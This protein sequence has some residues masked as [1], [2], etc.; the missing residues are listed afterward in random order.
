MDRGDEFLDPQFYV[1]D[2]EYLAE[3]TKVWN[4]ILNDDARKEQFVYLNN[5]WEVSIRYS[6]PSLDA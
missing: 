4:R 5:A 2:L 3:K 6:A 1:H